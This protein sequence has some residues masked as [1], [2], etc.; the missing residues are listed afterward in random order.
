M[1]FCSRGS[2]VIIRR[3]G[4]GLV[5]DGSSSIA[6]RIQPTYPADVSSRRIQ[7]TYPAAYPGMSSRRIQPTYPACRPA[8]PPAQLHI[9]PR[10]SCVSPLRDSFVASDIRVELPLRFS[11]ERHRKT[12]LL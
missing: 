2:F 3:S 8:S 1:L 11:V 4:P 5:A 6:V 9:P 7:P 10:G 12:R